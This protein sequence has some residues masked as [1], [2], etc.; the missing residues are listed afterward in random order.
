MSGKRAIVLLL[1]V[2][3]GLWTFWEHRTE[4]PPPGVEASPEQK[5]QHSGE[6]PNLRPSYARYFESVPATEDEAMRQLENLLSEEYDGKFE[7]AP[8]NWS[9]EE[10]VEWLLQSVP[11]EAL[12]GLLE[13]YR[14]LKERVK[15]SNLYFSEE[16][17]QAIAKRIGQQFKENSLQFANGLEDPLAPSLLEGWASQQPKAAASWFFDRHP[18]ALERPDIFKEIDPFSF[19]RFDHFPFNQQMKHLARGIVAS[20]YYSA[21][22]SLEHLA[23]F[24][25]FDLPLAESRLLSYSEY[26]PENSDW[27]VIVNEQTEKFGE[28]SPSAKGIYT[29]WGSVNWEEMI[30]AF[31]KDRETWGYPNDEIR[32]ISRISIRSSAQLGLKYPEFARYFPIDEVPVEIVA[33]FLYLTSRSTQL[34]YLTYDASRNIMK[35]GISNHPEGPLC[36]HPLIIQAVGQDVIKEVRATFEKK[37]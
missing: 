25:S 17:G 14:A 16:L 18:K 28:A 19:G 32:S 7:F 1:A 3:A 29:R 36:D 6:R 23:T 15:W 5:H 10:Q 13:R 24:H 37:P 4:E 22:E 21:I 31:P 9:H 34:N 12:A 30:K 11:D 27:Q 2:S 35:M 20:G 8:F 26:L 33:R